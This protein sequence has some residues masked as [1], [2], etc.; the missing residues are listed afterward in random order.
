MIEEIFDLLT[1]N[2]FIP[3]YFLTFI[4]SIARYNRYFDTVLRFFPILIAYTFLN[5]LLGVIIRNYP[6]FSLFNNLEYSEYNFI[7][8]NIFSLFFF[9]FFY[10]VYWKLISNERYKQWIQRMSITILLIYVVSCVF[11]NPFDT[12]FYYAHALG[13]WVLLFCVALY[14]IEKKRDKGT[15][16]Q[17]KNLV[18][19]IS[20]GLIIF[21]TI[22]PFI[23]IIGYWDYDIWKKFNL[24]T[25]L[26]VL[27][28]VMYS[29]FIT[30]FLKG[31]RRNF[32]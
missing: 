17:P 2:Y 25:V 7:L 19:W 5:E 15:I 29:L 1:E 12:D 20:I 28:V 16:Y 14:F 9:G 23:F 31:R 21:Y 13:S 24:R 6:D 18:F 11:Q 3:V 22:F 26:R 27:I 30:G 4:G 10:R 8:Y 32:G